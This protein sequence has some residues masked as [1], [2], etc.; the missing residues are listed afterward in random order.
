MF[1]DTNDYGSATIVVDDAHPAFTDLP[2]IDLS[3]T[4]PDG[5]EY[6]WDSSYA[7]IG[8]KYDEYTHLS[9]HATSEILVPLSTTFGAVSVD[10]VYLTYAHADE[11]S[12]FIDPSLTIVETAAEV[13]FNHAK[14][15]VMHGTPTPATTLLW[16]KDADGNF[17]VGTKQ[18]LL[19]IMNKGVLFTDLGDC[20]T[21]Y[22]THHYVQTA[23]VPCASWLVV[24]PSCHA[25]LWV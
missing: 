20:S 9:V 11:E 21:K 10:S 19:Q 14:S 17:E 5:T 3:G 1:F 7:N 8:G 25:I 6:E 23:V 12:L 22:W 16:V 13:V 2:Y 24:V 4:D 15:A 18:L